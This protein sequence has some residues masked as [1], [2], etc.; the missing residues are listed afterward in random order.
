MQR[1]RVIGIGRQGRVPAG[2]R[3]RAA[4]ERRQGQSAIVERLHMVALERQRAVEACE[5]RLMLLAGVE[6]QPVVRI[7]VGGTRIGFQGRRHQPQRFGQ[8]PLLIIR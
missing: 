7:D 5:R 3:L 6:R 8:A 1:F 4:A 2:Q